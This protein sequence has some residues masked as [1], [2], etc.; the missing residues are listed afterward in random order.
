[1][2]KSDILGLAQSQLQSGCVIPVRDAL[3]TRLDKL[4]ESRNPEN[5]IEAVIQEVN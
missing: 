2:K 5:N 3:Q 4:I 1:M